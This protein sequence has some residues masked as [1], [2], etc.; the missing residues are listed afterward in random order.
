LILVTGAG[1][2]TGV[3]VVRSLLINN[4]EVRILVRDESKIRDL[5]FVDDVDIVIGDMRS[6][7]VQRDAFD[8]VRS[9]YHIC[10]NMHEDELAIGL[11]MISVA[12]QFDVKHFVYHS[13]LHPQIEDM[14]HHWQKM[15]VEEAIFVSDLPYTIIQPAA[16]M[17]NVLME[18]ARIYEDKFIHVPYSID[19]KGSPVN[20]DD[21]AE[22]AATVLSKQDYIGGIYELCGPEILTPKDQASILGSHIGIELTIQQIT[23][24][25][26]KLQ[27]NL[28]N[29]STYS[30]KSLVDMF[31]YYD[32]YGFWGSSYVLESLLDRKPTGFCEFVERYFDK[33]NL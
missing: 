25:Q 21:V 24:D 23:L 4:I 31:V 15:R 11:S 9:V 33:F 27:N 13:V 6:E 32:K 26:W 20:L 17:Q 19:S 28:S 22:V 7:S 16:Y 8:G 3:A 5:E 29:F 2:K 1:G 10:P 18:K 30:L 12:K 14:P